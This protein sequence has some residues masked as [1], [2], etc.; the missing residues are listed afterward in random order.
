[1]RLLS[2]KFTKII[3]ITW[4]VLT[5]MYDT[6]CQ[7]IILLN[8]EFAEI[9]RWF[10]FLPS[11][12]CVSIMTEISGQICSNIQHIAVFISH[13]RLY[14]ITYLRYHQVSCKVKQIK[15]YVTSK[16]VLSL[17]YKDLQRSVR[18]ERYS[19]NMHTAFILLI[20]EIK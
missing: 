3:L 1:M 10:G 2:N 14:P 19:W 16:P 4:L 20:N 5:F 15:N 8:Y 13:L 18:E 12:L 11:F 17:L 9:N 7:I 6:R